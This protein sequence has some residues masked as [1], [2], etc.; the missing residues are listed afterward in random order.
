MVVFNTG[1]TNISGVD[2]DDVRL[3]KPTAIDPDL[4][5]KR[6]RNTVACITCHSSKQKCVPSDLNNIFWKP[7]IRCLKSKRQCTFD[8]SKRTRNRRTPK[9]SSHS[10]P[11]SQSISSVKR[12]KI[13]ND[14]DFIKPEEPNITYSNNSQYLN[15]SNISGGKFTDSNNISIASNNTGKPLKLGHF[16]PSS[17]PTQANNLNQQYSPNETIPN[18][19]I[20]SYQASSQNPNS[21]GTRMLPDTSTILSSVTPPVSSLWPNITKSISLDNIHSM[22]SRLSKNQQYNNHNTNTAYNINNNYKSRLPIPNFYSNGN[23]Y[24]TPAS[25]SK[26]NSEYYD[27]DLPSIVDN[28]INTGVNIIQS[29]NS[30]PET[31]N[32][33]S[34]ALVHSDLS[35]IMTDSSASQFK[36]KLKSLLIKQK[37]KV[38]NLYDVLNVLAVKWSDTLVKS[39]YADRVTDPISLNLLTY[40]EADRRLNLYRDVIDRDCRL[41]FVKI[42]KD[43]TVDKL[44]TEKPIF[45]TTI[46][47]IVSILMKQ[48][49]TTEE[50]IFNLNSFTLHLIK[51]EIFQHNRKSIELLE[52]LLTLCLWYNFPEWSNNTHYHLF[53]YISCSLTKE[54]GP[55][56]RNRSFAMF[57]EESNH[58]NRFKKVS[59]LEAYEN[60]YK[61]QIINYISATNI[62]LFLRQRSH[63]QWSSTLENAC[64]KIINYKNSNEPSHNFTDDEMW[65]VFLKLNH[66][67]EKIQT[68]LH[69]PFDTHEERDDPEYSERHINNLCTRYKKQLDIIFVQIP[70]DR[71]RILSF[72]FSVESFLHQFIVRRFLILNGN[73]KELPSNITTSFV[74]C[75]E[76]CILALKEF[77]KL[78]PRL[79]ASLPL[80]HMSRIIYTVGM[81]LLRCRYSSIAIPVLNKYI[82]QTDGVVDLVNQVSDLLEKTS[83]IYVY[84][85]FILKFQYVIALFVQ[86]YAS[87]VLE[88]KKI[89]KHKKTNGQKAASKNVNNKK[90][91]SSSS[92]FKHNHNQELFTNT[93]NIPNV[94]QNIPAHTTSSFGNNLGL[95]HNKTTPLTET[96]D[97][98]STSV[99]N[100]TEYLSDMDS[101]AL[102]FNHL[103]DEFWSDIFSGYT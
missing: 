55:T 30:L 19:N 32:E 25:C 31:Q 11:S 79:V 15:N 53:N 83:K 86:T 22:D 28:S 89:L 88:D 102:G 47:C 41:P 48:D 6:K 17:L 43:T 44:R 58:F 100:L 63:I 87:R 78:T 45:F 59:P 82:T 85:T 7:C 96:E 33:I 42:S 66:L 65:V 40:E 99:G 80:F 52:S 76:C 36:K 24:S 12:Q 51:N 67:L 101:L 16:T 98:P 49:E 68:Y 77:L 9:S 72:Y 2:S 73:F 103:N 37:G 3:L 4:W 91:D 93:Q 34:K 95:K 97:S 29:V 13:D 56:S 10:S 8:L 35:N 92:T 5:Q 27:N 64:D 69:E 39:S 26:H 90:H 20:Q 23:I 61:I 46:I 21:E 75:C 38:H 84:N 60:G 70:D 14:I 94:M 50:T 62:A 57:P 71:H 81:L 1:L 74:R 54:L 18:N